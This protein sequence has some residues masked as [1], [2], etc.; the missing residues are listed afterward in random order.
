MFEIVVKGPELFNEETQT[1]SQETL[2]VLHFEHSLLSLSKWEAK[3]EIPFI[4]NTER[5]E[6][7][8][9]DY[10]R[11]M[12][13]EDI[14]DDLFNHIDSSD[15]QALSEYISSKQTATWFTES[16]EKRHQSQKITAEII[17]YWM[18][19]LNIPFECQTWHLNRLITLIRVTNEKQTPPKKMSKAD[20]MKRHASLN[21]SRRAAR[22]R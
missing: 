9:R 3:Y 20:N 12:C 8:M 21:A 14:T 5:T 18:V 2:A 15:F 10:I 6:E 4:D 17:Y 7:Q 19:A 11:M 1:F 16:E 13:Q 22:R